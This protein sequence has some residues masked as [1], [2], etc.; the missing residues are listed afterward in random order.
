MKRRRRRIETVLVGNARVKIYQRTRTVASH[1]YLTY[2][3]CDYTS[4]WRRLRGFGH[5]QAVLEEAQ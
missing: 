1:K 4:G 5:H 3:V 2:E